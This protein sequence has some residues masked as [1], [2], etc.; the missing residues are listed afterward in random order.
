MELKEFTKKFLP[1]YEAK[2]KMEDINTIDEEDMFHKKHF[3]E[4]LRNFEGVKFAERWI[5]VAEKLPDRNIIVLAKHEDG[6][7]SLAKFNGR[8]FRVEQYS[9]P[10]QVTH[11]RQ[12]EFK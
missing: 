7:F 12:I 9:N 5:P 11:W 6:N 1:D 2:K 3:S 4:A 8:Y 10:Y